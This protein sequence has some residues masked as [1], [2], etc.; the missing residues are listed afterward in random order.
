MARQCIVN[1]KLTLY[2]KIIRAI[3]HQ[4]CFSNNYIFCNFYR[5]I[6]FV[7][8]EYFIYIYMYIYYIT[9]LYLSYIYLSFYLLGVSRY[10]GIDDNRDIQ[11]ND[12]RYRVNLV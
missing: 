4:C 5:F 9:S 1:V 7:K 11:I 8:L 2:Q 12:Y 6:W 3:K 10:T